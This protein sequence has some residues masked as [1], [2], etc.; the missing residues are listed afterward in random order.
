[1]S[2]LFLFGAAT[3]LLGS[4]LGIGGGLVLVPLFTQVYDLSTPM[5]VGTSLWCVFFNS[6]SGSLV[7]LRQKRVDIPLGLVFAVSTF[8]G[9]L[10]GIA[11]AH[12]VGRPTFD[13]LF[14]LLLAAAGV[15]LTGVGTSGR[16]GSPV[17]PVRG[18]R[19]RERTLTDA[20]GNSFT[21]R[22]S[23][24][25][26]ALVSAGVG[27]FSS[28]FGIGGGILHVPLLHRIFGMDI[29][30]AAA[31]SHF[32]LVFTSLA[33]AMTQTIVGGVWQVD[34]LLA[35]GLGVALGAQIGARLALRTRPRRLVI[36][37]A[38]AMMGAGVR[39]VWQGATR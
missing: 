15:L 5:A 27:V 35:L 25:L 12:F 29:H 7:Y 38:V 1:M 13:L 16:N 14:G 34:N 9:A 21:Y 10:L 31:T 24:R 18:L 6:L 26:G 32:I 28:F 2:L 39:L 11:L 22:A 17:R 20:A 3:G 30:I 19:G 4:L 36:L 23:F 37:V 33:G 8:P